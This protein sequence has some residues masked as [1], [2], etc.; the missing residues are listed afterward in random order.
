[1]SRL[2]TQM[3]NSGRDFASPGV[4]YNHEPSEHQNTSELLTIVAIAVALSVSA[5][6]CSFLIAK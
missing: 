2:L 6:S 5:Q 1:M 3:A 4:S